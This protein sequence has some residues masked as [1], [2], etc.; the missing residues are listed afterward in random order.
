MR[1]NR[2]WIELCAKPFRSILASFPK[3]GLSGQCPHDHLAWRIRDNVDKILPPSHSV[4]KIKRQNGRFVHVVL[5][6]AIPQNWGT[7][8]L[9][10]LDTAPRLQLELFLPIVRNPPRLRACRL[11]RLSTGSA[12]SRLR[13]FVWTKPTR[14]KVSSASVTRRIL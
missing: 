7:P 13:S 2:S 10:A 8:F 12:T 3:N 1:T 6:G 4:R 11:D 9:H 14:R 5:V